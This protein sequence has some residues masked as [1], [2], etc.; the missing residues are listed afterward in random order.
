MRY[1]LNLLN[2]KNVFLIFL[3][4]SGNIM[5]SYSNARGN[6]PIKYYQIGDTFITVWFGSNAYTYSYG[7]AGRENVE[8]MKILARNGSGLSSYISKNVKHL[9]D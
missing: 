8:T 5:E 1:K 4:L 2:S 9:F 7:R 3:T 6:S